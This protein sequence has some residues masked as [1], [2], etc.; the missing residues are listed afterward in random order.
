[1]SVA[2]ANISF[3][4]NSS[5]IEVLDSLVQLAPE[6]HTFDAI[7]AYVRLGHKYQIDTLFDPSL[8]Y[9]KACFTTDFEARRRWLRNNPNHIPTGWG[10]HPADKVFAV[11]VVNLARLVQCDAILPSALAVCCSLEATALID[12][13]LREDG[14]RERLSG[15]DLNLCIAGVRALT[16]R[17]SAA[18]TT[19]LADVGR[20][21]CKAKTS[22]PRAM[23][24]LLSDRQFAFSY[25]QSF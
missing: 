2:A 14:T 13:F 11:G 1:M 5:L 3:T 19:P 6:S 17:A 21:D 25:C 16:H 12:G 9:L 20:A 18:V 8:A 10:V 15:D 22:C 7:S 4:L 24:E 23:R